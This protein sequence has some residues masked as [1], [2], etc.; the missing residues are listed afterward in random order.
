MLKKLSLILAAAT[1]CANLGIIVPV[2]ASAESETVLIETDFASCN[3]GAYTAENQTDGENDL[4]KGLIM[5]NDSVLSSGYTIKNG[6][7]YESIS[8]ADIVDD[9]GEK[10]LRLNTFLGTYTKADTIEQSTYPIVQSVTQLPTSGKVKIDLEL[11]MT[12]HSKLLMNHSKPNHAD[13]QFWRLE[14]H[15]GAYY[16]VKVLYNTG[17][18]VTAFYNQYNK[19]TI[20]YDTETGAMSAFVNDTP[21]WSGQAQLPAWNKELFIRHETNMGDAYKPVVTFNE[22]DS[23]KIES[24]TNPQYIYIK[25]LKMAKYTDIAFESVTPENGSKASTPK[26]AVFTFTNNIANVGGATV[27]AVGG[28]TVELDTSSLVIDGKTVKVPY[29]FEEG[30]VYTVA[31]TGVSD[32]AT[33][34]DA[35]TTFTAEAWAF[36]NIIEPVIEEPKDESVYFVNEDFENC[37][38][39]NLI[40]AKNMHKEWGIEK[41]TKTS[42]TE[43]ADGRKVLLLN[44]GSDFRIK[45][46]KKLG[47]LDNT[48]TLTYDVCLG[49]NTTQ[50][51]VDRDDYKR[52]SSGNG[53]AY[54]IVAA[55]RNGAF[56]NGSDSV[57][58][59]TK[60]VWHKI[61]VTI[62]DADGTTVYVDGNKILNTAKAEIH[63]GLSATGFFRFKAVSDSVMVDNLKLYLNKSKTVLTE[64]SPSYDAVDVPVACP[65][66]FTYSGEIGDVSGAKLIVKPSDTNEAIILTNGNGMTVSKENNVVKLIL[67]DS[68]TENL[69]YGIEFSGIKSKAGEE[70]EAVRTRFSTVPNAEWEIDTV[71]STVISPTSKKYSVKVKHLDG[72]AG[73]IMAVAVYNEKGNLA[74]FAMSEPATSDGEWAQL[75][76]TVDYEEGNSVKIFIWDNIN[77]MNLISGILSD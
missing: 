30:T 57:T 38:N 29:D 60:G 33:S 71:E 16:Q 12:N 5:A 31:L 69:G 13:W 63:D 3:I 6:D 47:L 74:G 72:E 48:T 36:S 50:F 7:T 27:T 59:L 28:E 49:A 65:I 75:D 21:V 55:W 11:K 17:T 51:N 23:T 58:A 76:A 73:A 25:S 34:V 40:L 45:Y 2:S 8:E 70:L 18:G 35:S 19:H 37:D 39:E 15:N 4:R 54:P 67:N 44:A 52:D 32:G 14:R 41:S 42:I 43:T 62:S 68:L 22:E 64:I 53:V 56:V 77:D 20:I 46:D 24:V 26:E 61:M 9:D 66:K 1:L 10:V